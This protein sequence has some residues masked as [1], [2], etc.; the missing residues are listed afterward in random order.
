MKR[1]VGPALMVLCVLFLS[2]KESGMARQEVQHSTPSPQWIQLQQGI[3]VLKIWETV[4]PK[5]P[6][7]VLF[8]L[9]QDEYKKFLQNSEDYVNGLNV[10]GISSTHKI[11]SCDLVKVDVSAPSTT[12]YLVVLKHEVDTVS[13]AMSSSRVSP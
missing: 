4:G 9:S 7:V 12:L 11:H 1:I 13:T 6:Q 5:W 2:A 3:Q 10:L 8:Q